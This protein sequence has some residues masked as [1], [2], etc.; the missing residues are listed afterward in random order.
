LIGKRKK[1][2]MKSALISSLL[3]LGMA[4]SAQVTVYQNDFEQAPVD[5]V[6]ED[7]LVLSGEFAVKTD[8]MGKWLE[9]PGAPLDT[10]SLQFGPATN[11]GV[12]VTA[13]VLGQAQKRRMPTFSV[14]L[15]GVAGYQLRVAPA[16][17]MVELL[18]DTEVVS[19]IPFQWKAG[20][21][22]WLELQ[23]RLSAP[24]E[25][26][27]EGRAWQGQAKPAAWA[28]TYKTA[29]APITGRASVVGCPFSGLPLRFDDLSLT[30]A[31]PVQGANAAR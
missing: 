19:T 5:S 27:V 28:I 24:G 3:S 8:G 15:G 7:F 20:E 2:P 14:G 6:P 17:A 10:F 31:E 30:T 1:K 18:K 25:W 26:V 4:V 29:A 11:S 23:I 21:W 12:C 16:K 13:R 22:T 9:L